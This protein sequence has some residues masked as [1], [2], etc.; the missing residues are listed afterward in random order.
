MITNCN[1]LPEHSISHFR[2]VVVRTCHQCI[3]TLLLSLMHVP[4]INS[5]NTVYIVRKHHNQ[6][7]EMSSVQIANEWSTWYWTEWHTYKIG[8][9]TSQFYMGNTGHGST[10]VHRMTHQP[11]GGCNGELA[12]IT[13]TTEVS[14]ITEVILILVRTFIK[15]NFNRSNMK[16]Q[17]TTAPPLCFVCPT[18]A[19]R[20][21]SRDTPCSGSTVPWPYDA[22]LF[23]GYTCDS[24]LCQP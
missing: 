11:Q 19:T 14:W 2:T 8:V 24:W 15:I 7:W 4:P 13:D 17:T 3:L 9:R 1:L 20:C 18:V 5:N 10:M 16:I 23:T 21:P 12:V 22:P 6:R